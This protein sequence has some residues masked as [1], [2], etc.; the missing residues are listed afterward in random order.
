MTASVMWVC[1]KSTSPFLIRWAIAFVPKGELGFAVRLTLTLRI[2][3]HTLDLLAESLHPP[4]SRVPSRKNRSP[5]GDL[6]GVMDR[7][8]TKPLIVP[9]P[10]LGLILCW[11]APG[12]R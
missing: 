4:L 2:W 12:K 1:T 9:S 5:V 8:G 7:R 11:T 6:I 3:H 10:I